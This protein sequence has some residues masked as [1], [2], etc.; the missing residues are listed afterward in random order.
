MKHTYYYNVL[1][2]AIVDIDYDKLF[3]YC[4]KAVIAET[5]EEVTVGDIFTF[6]ESDVE[7]CVQNVTGCEDFIECDNES[8]AELMCEHFIEY[9]KSQF[10]EDWENEQV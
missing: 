9:L 10:G 2:E 1:I 6:F 3:H 7:T 5:D 4:Q 8:V